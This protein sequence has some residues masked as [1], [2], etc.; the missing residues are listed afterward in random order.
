MKKSSY[1]IESHRYHIQIPHH[2]K[3]YYLAD[4]LAICQAFVL[5]RRVII[6]NSTIFSLIKSYLEKENFI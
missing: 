6:Q 5:T 3:E 4:F 2:Y 1:N